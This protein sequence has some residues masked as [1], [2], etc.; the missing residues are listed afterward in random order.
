LLKNLD[1]NVQ[2]RIPVVPTVN[3]TKDEIEAI[4]R[5]VKN[6]GHRKPELLW[7]NRLGAGKYK[8]LGREY[9]AGEIETIEDEKKEELQLSVDR[10]FP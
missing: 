5:E 1:A 6:I 4:A 7:F 2:V 9:K 10:I 3:D 8:S